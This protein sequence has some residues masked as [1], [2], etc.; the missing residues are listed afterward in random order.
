MI[1]KLVENF[2]H[3]NTNIPIPSI[4]INFILLNRTIK[5]LLN[6]LLVYIFVT[7]MV[8]N[9]PTLSINYFI[10]LICTISS[11]VFYIL[12]LSFPS[13]YL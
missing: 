6:F 7:I 9:Y 3:E 8:Y 13:C 4:D 11:V 2:Q 5:F 12:D 1:N 10:L